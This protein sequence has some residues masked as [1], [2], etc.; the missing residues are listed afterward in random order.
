LLQKKISA[1]KFSDRAARPA[2]TPEIVT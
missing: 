1:D 2:R